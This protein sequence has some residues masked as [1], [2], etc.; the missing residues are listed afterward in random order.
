MGAVVVKRPWKA[1]RSMEAWSRAFVGSLQMCFV[2]LFLQ[3]S[4]GNELFLMHPSIWFP[5]SQASP[6]WTIMSPQYV[7]SDRQRT[8]GSTVDP[9]GSQV[10]PSD[11]VTMPLPHSGGK[12]SSLGQDWP[13]SS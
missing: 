4:I 2:Q 5:S 7:Q 10:S 3:S 8:P 9:G 6:A 12:Q 1:N 13:G 11:A